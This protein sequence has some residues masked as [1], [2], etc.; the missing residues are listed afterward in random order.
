MTFPIL[1]KARG[2][3]YAASLAGAPSVRVVEPTHSEAIDALRTE[4]RER[5]D[6]GELLLLDIEAEGV[7]SLAGKYRDDPTLNEIRNEAYKLRDVERHG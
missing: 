3:A 1:V 5:V 7:V 6:R 2:D 4:I